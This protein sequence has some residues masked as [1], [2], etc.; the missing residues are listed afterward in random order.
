MNAYV[1]DSLGSLSLFEQPPVTVTPH[2]TSDESSGDEENHYRSPP[3][4][5]AVPRSTRMAPMP[6]GFTVIGPAA[7]MLE[8]ISI[9]SQS[10]Q[11]PSAGSFAPQVVP[12][13]MNDF[14]VDDNA[15]DAAVNEI[16]YEEDPSM[17]EN[18]LINIWDP[19]MEVTEKIEDDEQLGYLLE[20]MLQG[21]V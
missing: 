19:S 1:I 8:P 3:M 16:F 9:F 11:Q 18:D 15:F 14:N 13:V 6:T 10:E 12:D 4:V 7:S 21:V 20:Q 2:I 5:A 17:V